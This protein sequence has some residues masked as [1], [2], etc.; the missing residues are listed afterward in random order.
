M[1]SIAID[2][3]V[4]KTIEAERLSFDETENDVLR[5]ILKIS[6]PKRVGPAIV[7]PDGRSWSSK[8]VTLPHGTMVRMEYNGVEHNGAIV[9]GAWECGGSRFAGPSPAAAAVATTKA[10]GTPSLNG[11]IYWQAKLPGQSN[12]I[13]ISKMRKGV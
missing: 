11:W 8:G 2:V 5:R 1:R 3:D 10:G 13:A 9:D 7:E 6:T 4:H 12:W